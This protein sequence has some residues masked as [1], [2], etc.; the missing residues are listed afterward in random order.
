M[1]GY[2]QTPTLDFLTL[3][4]M[5]RTAKAWV[6][7]PAKISS[8]RQR[9][10]VIRNWVVGNGLLSDVPDTHSMSD[11]EKARVWKTVFEAVE[12]GI[13]KLRSGKLDIYKSINAMVFYMEKKGSSGTTISGHTHKI[14]K[15]YRYLKLPVDAEDLKETVRKVDSVSVTDD[16]NLTR[17]E[18]RRTLIHGNPK[19]KALVSFLVSTGARLG[20]AVQ[21]RIR[22]IDFNK[23]PAVVYFPARKTKTKRKRFSFLSSECVELL[24]TQIKDDC[25]P[26]KSEW[27]FPGWIPGQER[28]SQADKH[29]SPS[30]AYLQVRNV[31]ALA[32]L[33]PPVGQHKNARAGGK[34]GAH[35]DYHPHVLRSTSLEIAKSAGYPTDW[36]EYIVGHNLGT[37]ESYLPNEDK[38][39]E[40]WLKLCEKSFCFLHVGPD[41][42]DIQAEI[43]KRAETTREEMKDWVK[44][45]VDE[46]YRKYGKPPGKPFD[47]LKILA[48]DEAAFAQAISEGYEEAG[49]I[50]G[51]IIMRRKR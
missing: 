36:A 10:D 38:M 5:N 2:Q 13:S 14:V 9:R 34:T 33:V 24:K 45:K 23:K 26:R 29:I 19:Q 8:V 3:Q 46:V 1:V 27:L 7:T 37:Q 22:D 35:L 4:L 21:V 11:E 28:H 6:E 12:Q 18:I 20:E 40:E 16:R 48:S 51:S 44:Q 30:S 42:A 17:P 32:G 49:R 50:N 25:M 41:P 43:K 47:V 15:L 39:A 31:F